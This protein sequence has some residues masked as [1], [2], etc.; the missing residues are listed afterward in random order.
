MAGRWHPNDRRKIQRSLEIYLKT[1]KP[2]S[3]VYDE[4]RL[5]QEVEPEADREEENRAGFR[6]PTL[7][8]WVHAAKDVLCTRLDSRVDKMIQKGLS[9][10]R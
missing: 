7:V 9:T 10:L 8:F 4:K 6:Y 5:K 3:Q 1:G 2:A